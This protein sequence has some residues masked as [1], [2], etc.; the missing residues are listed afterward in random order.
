M[1]APAACSTTPCRSS[2]SQNPFPSRF[3]G[4]FAFI[5]R[6][7]FEFHAPDRTTEEFLYELQ[8]S[9]LLTP[10]QKQSL[11]GLP[12]QL[13][14]DQV[15]QIRADGDGT[16]RLARF[17]PAPGQRDRAAR[18][19]AGHPILRKPRR[20][21][22]PPQH[23]LCPSIRLIVFA[24][25]A[26]PGVAEGQDWTKPG[27]S[28]FLRRFGPADFRAE[29]LLGRKF[30]G[31]LALAGAGAVHC[32]P[33]PTP[34]RQGRVPGQGQR[35][36]YRRGHRYVRQHEIGGFWRGPKPHQAGQGSPGQIHRQPPQRPHRPGRFCQGRL[37]CRAA[38]LGP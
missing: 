14:P 13:R 20:P 16:S 24:V 34:P 21:P 29:S 15:R 10:E 1:C 17:R 19:A 30:P 5:W 7:V 2:A 6:S 35:H 12:G 18:V 32:R 23:D 36:R 25:A 38:D 9:Q 11:A 28:L 22:F 3:Q 31:R 26:R 8:E 33:G 4:P 37:H 27:F